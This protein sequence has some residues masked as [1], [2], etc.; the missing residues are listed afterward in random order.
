[1]LVTRLM[2]R[3]GEQMRWKDLACRRMGESRRSLCERR[4][5]GVV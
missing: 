1:M 2:Q 3:E 5:L 4:S